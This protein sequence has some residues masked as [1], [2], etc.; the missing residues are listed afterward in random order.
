[1]N[2]VPGEAT[3]QGVRV[4]GWEVAVRAG[5]RRALGAAVDA[6]VRPEDLAL[7]PSPEGRGVV[8]GKTF[9][10]AVTRV[11]V[12]LGEDVTVQIDGASAEAAAVEPGTV[13]VVELTAPEVMVAEPPA[14]P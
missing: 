3:A 1:M 9:F 7:R 14:A 12:L 8:V 5:G 2:R 4:L 6:L 13:V 11:A 10:G